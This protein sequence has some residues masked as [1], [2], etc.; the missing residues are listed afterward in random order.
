[1][2]TWLFNF[3]SQCLRLYAFEESREFSSRPEQALAEVE[4][5]RASLG[6]YF[7][8]GEKLQKL[9]RLARTSSRPRGERNPSTWRARRSIE[10]GITLKSEWG[11]TRPR[12]NVCV[13]RC[14]PSAPTPHMHRRCI[15][16]AHRRETRGLRAIRR[17]V[18]GMGVVVHGAQLS[19]CSI[20][21][22][23]AAQLE[24][25][26]SYTKQRITTDR[27]RRATPIRQ[28]TPHCHFYNRPTGDDARWEMLWELPSL[29]HKFSLCTFDTSRDWL[30]NHQF[31]EKHP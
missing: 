23:S 16:A 21:N 6:V 11:P 26:S 18:H 17:C 25:A 20:A 28:K 9:W 22:K 19:N 1:M 24:S 15:A 30:S 2:V 14:E 12:F 29:F 27:P 3:F 31:A 13:R 8:S 5:H 7:V 10:R 4:H